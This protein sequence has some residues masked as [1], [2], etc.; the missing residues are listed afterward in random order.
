MTAVKVSLT[1]EPK[2]VHDSAACLAE[3]A[4]KLATWLLDI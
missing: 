2:G 4:V 1:E 3:N